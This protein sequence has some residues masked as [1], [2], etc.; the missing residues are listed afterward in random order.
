MNGQDPR[1]VDVPALEQASREWSATFD[2]MNDMVCLLAR[3]GTVLR[4]N[5]G[6]LDLLGL[7]SGEAVGKKCFELMHG[8][9]TFFERC[10]YQAMLRTGRREEFELP[11]GD[12]WYQVT[13][14]PLFGEAEEIIGCLLYTSPSPRDGLL[15]RMPSSA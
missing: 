5:R 2:A 6:M 10:P 9:H 14:D 12:R 7:S 4:C 3:D 13:A 11:L 8:G 1:N 15:S